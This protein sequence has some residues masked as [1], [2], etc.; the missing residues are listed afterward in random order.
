MLVKTSSPRSA[1]DHG[2]DLG[3]RHRRHLV[4]ELRELLDVHVRQQIRTR[5]EKLPELD[6]RRTELFER[7]PEACAPS[8]VASLS[9]GLRSPR[10]HSES[11]SCARR[12]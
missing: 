8:R 3:E 9:R 10:E 7:A 1:Q 5:G 4:D 6:I 12:A 2:L 11:R